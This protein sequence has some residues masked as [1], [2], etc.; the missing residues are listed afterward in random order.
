M[1]TR[2]QPG[3]GTKEDTRMVQGKYNATSLTSQMDSYNL[4]PQQLSNKKVYTYQLFYPQA[5]PLKT[6][7]YTNKRSISRVI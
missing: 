2:P 3:T 5:N 7:I 1:G 4:T 6:I